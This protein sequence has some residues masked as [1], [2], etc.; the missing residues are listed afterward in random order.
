MILLQLQ[1]KTNHF[2]GFCSHRRK[3][4]MTVFPMI[5]D[6]RQ[7][8]EY[9]LKCGKL[10]I[11]ENRMILLQLQLILIIFSV[12]VHREEKRLWF[13]CGNLKILENRMILLQ[14]QLNANHFLG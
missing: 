14:L 1:L 4:R 9:W 6:H 3:N 12:S 5:T 13:K 10:Q 2:L 7:E 11:L 8:K